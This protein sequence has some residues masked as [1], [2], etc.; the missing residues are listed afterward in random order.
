[1]KTILIIDD[2]RELILEMEEILADEGFS[3]S[4][5]HDPYEGR[6]MMLEGAYDIVLL[7]YKMPGIN[8]IEFL[9]SLKHCGVKSKIILITGSLNMNQ[10]LQES[11]CASY[12]HDVVTKPFDIDK[13]IATLKEI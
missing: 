10:L 12:V 4:K 1:M 7:D 2:D 5:A 8:G 13:L 9:L 6:K 11:D 3:I